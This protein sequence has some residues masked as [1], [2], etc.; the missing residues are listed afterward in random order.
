MTLVQNTQLVQRLFK[1]QEDKKLQVKKSVQ[2][3]EK[4]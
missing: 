4:T 3:Y 2:P 1:K